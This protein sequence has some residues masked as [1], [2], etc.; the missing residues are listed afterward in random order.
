MHVHVNMIRSWFDVNS[1]SPTLTRLT[2]KLHA[3]LSSLTTCPA[4]RKASTFIDV[5]PNT[6]VTESHSTEWQL[7]A[8][9][10][11]M[12]CLY[13]M[14]QWCV[15]IVSW[16]KADDDFKAQHFFDH[17]ILWAIHRME[18]I[19]LLWA[20][21]IQG[22]CGRAPFRFDAACCLRIHLTIIGTA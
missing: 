10:H 7:I 8:P 9:Y 12:I 20:I 1:H 13:H 22:L 21:Q 15:I 14:T 6:A 18:T 2:L 11:H 5:M 16:L 4:V 17:P 3:W 19:H